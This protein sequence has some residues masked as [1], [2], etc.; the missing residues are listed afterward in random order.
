MNRNFINFTI[1][2]SCAWLFVLAAPTVFGAATLDYR[3]DQILIQP[4]AGISRAALTTFHA[5][6]GARV[7]QAFP[8]VGGSQVIALPAGETVPG[9]IAKYQQIGLVEFA[10][11][12]VRPPDVH[13]P[14]WLVVH[15]HQYHLDQRHV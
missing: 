1:V 8:A 9:L 3:T 10:E 13:Q 5:A 15:L 11:P 14:D 12:R 4:K 6:H 2:G 7:A